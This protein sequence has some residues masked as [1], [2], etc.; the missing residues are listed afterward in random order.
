[1]ESHTAERRCTP[2]PQIVVVADDADSLR[3]LWRDWLSLF[4]FDVIEACT[5]AEALVLATRLCP[6]A[7]LMDLA[8]PVM[9]GLEATRCIRAGI[10][11]PEGGELPVA[12]R[13]VPV[14]ALTAHAQPEDRARCIAAGMDDYLSKPLTAAEMV[15]TILRAVRSVGGERPSG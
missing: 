3:H 2:R 15:Q 12:R 1:M 4:G 6:A 9:D 11:L 8:M 10:D 7:V 13:S 5:G 14:V